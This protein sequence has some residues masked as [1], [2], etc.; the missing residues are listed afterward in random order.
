MGEETL[1]K[2]K[3]KLIDRIMIMTPV[4]LRA[5]CGFLS[6][7]TSAVITVI[8]SLTIYESVLRSYLGYPEA[9]KTLIMVVG[10][11][12]STWQFV[13]I[14][15]TLSA[16]FQEVND[17][18]N[19]FNGKVKIANAGKGNKG[20]SIEKQIYGGANVV[21]RSIAG[22]LCCLAIN[23]ASLLFTYVIHLSVLE[24]KDFPGNMIMLIIIS[25]PIITSWAFMRAETTIRDLLKIDGIGEKLRKRAITVLSKKD[26]E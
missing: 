18:E 2:N 25:G 19:E 16:L 13:N 3:G 6:A 14:N 21:L 11:L 26:K 20:E 4:V 7:I 5:F 10:P 8:F 22:L 24:G 9:F 12:I 23:F 1:Q 17:K 15:S